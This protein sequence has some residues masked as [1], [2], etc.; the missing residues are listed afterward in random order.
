VK[1]ISQIHVF[2]TI[3]KVWKRQKHCCLKYFSIMYSGKVIVFRRF[4]NF[5]QSWGEAII[6]GAAIKREIMVAIQL[7]IKSWE[8]R[9]QEYD[10]KRRLVCL[11]HLFCKQFYIFSKVKCPMEFMK[12]AKLTKKIVKFR[13]NMINL[14]ST[15][16][17]YS[18]S[19]FCLH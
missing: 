7:L 2:G 5:S 19:H 17:G 6:R 12:S 16:P 11:R 4:R 14:V 10:A 15:F 18:S 8:F 1:S 9:A 13:K 3:R